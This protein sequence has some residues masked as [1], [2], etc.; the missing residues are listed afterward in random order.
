MVVRSMDTVNLVLL[1]H[2]RSLA[3]DERVHEGRYDSPL[4]EVGRGQAKRLAE[5]WLTRGVTFDRVVA[6]PLQRASETAEIVA[7]VLGL[8]VE[9]SDEW[10]ELDK[11]PLAG[12]SFEEA[13]ERYPPPAF[14]H[15]FLPFAGSGESQWEGTSRAAS[16]LSA[17]VRPGV[18]RTLVVAHGGI[19]NAAMRVVTGAP[20]GPLG[21]GIAFAFGDL[22]HI[23]LSYRP[24]KHQWVVTAF[25]PG[26]HD[27]P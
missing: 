16:A 14:I 4:T 9:K 13:A 23:E 11:G 7:A 18:D 20:T 19:L 12:M 8:S 21:Q 22:G 17:L 27:L 1:R 15:P 10:Q 24:G 3:D 6:S 25:N 2:G 5:E 26:A